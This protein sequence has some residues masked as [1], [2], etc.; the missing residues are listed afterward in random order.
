MIVIKV[1]IK[2]SLKIKVNGINF[3][4]IYDY[5]PI[6]KLPPLSSVTLRGPRNAVIARIG[7]QTPFQFIHNNNFCLI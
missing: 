5:S 2:E 1:W 7:L 4:S 6:T 3:P